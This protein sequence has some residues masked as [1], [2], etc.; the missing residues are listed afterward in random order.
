MPLS[1]RHTKSALTVLSQCS[2]NALT[3]LSL[4]LCCALTASHCLIVTV[5]CSHRLSLS[6][7]GPGGNWEDEYPENVGNRQH[8]GTD[9]APF[10]ADEQVAKQTEE[11]VPTKAEERKANEGSV[12]AA[13]YVKA[14]GGQQAV[15][16]TE[17]AV[18]GGDA[19]GAAE[20]VITD[21]RPQLATAERVVEELHDKAEQQ[22]ASAELR[23]TLPDVTEVD[24]N[25]SD[26]QAAQM[27]KGSPAAVPDESSATGEGLMVTREVDPPS[28]ITKAAAVE[29]FQCLNIGLM[30][31]LPQGK[32][33][34][35]SSLH[36]S[37]A[38]VLGLCSNN[39]GK[40]H[41]HIALA[42][43]TVPCAN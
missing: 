32:L 2:H 1:T 20:Q 8:P 7:C 15:A 35:Q 18:A 21:L 10:K 6:H 13:A 17:A 14:S 33:C 29:I 26:S 34:T 30:V 5:L 9:I 37:P 28:P 36:L 41:R 31:H 38:A 3:M 40:S 11:T 42:V 22:T 23:A 24:S 19:L 27:L 16:A 25:D 39:C 12:E 4:C 43:S